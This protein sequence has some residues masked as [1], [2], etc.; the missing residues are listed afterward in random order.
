MEENPLNKLPG[1]MG[2]E[3]APLKQKII[4]DELI[5]SELRK[6]GYLDY[7]D[8]DENEAWEKLEEKYDC[9]VDDQWRNKHYDFYCYE[10]TTADGYSVYVATVNTDNICIS[11]DIHYYEN[12]L[13]GEIERA[14]QDGCS[15]YI[16]DLDAGYFMYAVEA[17][18]DKMIDKIRKEIEEQLINKG[19][20][21]EADT[22]T[23][24]TA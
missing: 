12:D 22:A 14:I 11:E 3:N 8:I 21:R 5:T 23:E 17:C 1:F 24:A 15:M 9:E 20:E 10:E 2:T 7:G 4:T 16:D 19:Y 6:R 18:Y 13:Q